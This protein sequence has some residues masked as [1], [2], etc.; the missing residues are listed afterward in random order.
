MCHCYLGRQTM[1]KWW[2]DTL[3]AV[4]P[5]MKSHTGAAMTLGKGIIYGTSLYMSKA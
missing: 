5:N 4:H 3:F 2:V 1:I